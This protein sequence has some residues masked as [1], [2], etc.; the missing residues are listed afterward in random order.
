MRLQLANGHI[1]RAMGL[2][3]RV[4]VTTCGIEDEHSFAVVDFGQ[5]PNY[6]VVLGRP[7]MRKIKMI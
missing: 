2:L 1:Q 7:F 6:D 3:E 4:L 5:S